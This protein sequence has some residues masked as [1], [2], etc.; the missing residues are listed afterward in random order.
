MPWRETCTMHERQLFIDAWLSRDF[1]LSYLCERFGISR[2]TGYKWIGRFRAEGDL[3][4]TDRSRAR[5]SQAHR[6]PDAVIEQI[7]N[8]KHQHPSWGPVTLAGKLYREN[9]N[10]HWPAVSTIGEILKRHGLVKPRRKRHKTPPH[11]AP[12]AHARAPNQVWSADFKGQFRLG[13]GRWCYPLTISDNHSRMLL[14]C[15]GL[16]GPRYRL[17]R[18]ACEQVFREYG[19]PE[20]IRTDNGV[21]FAARALGGLCP[22][23]IW[24]IRLEVMPERIEPGC[25]QQN[26]RHERMHRTLKAE[27]VTPPRYNFSAQQRAFNR[28]RLEYNEQRPHQSLGRGVCPIDCHEPATRA[29]PETLPEIEYPDPWII[30]KVKQQGH[31]KLHG[32]E[33]YLTKS[34]AGE[35][36]G[37]ELI[38]DHRW[39]IYFGILKLGILDG[40][41]QRVIRPK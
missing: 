1:E 41:L 26:P 11:T 39:L 23:S 17:T 35:H 22:L 29:Y 18:K 37:L 3:G 5:K 14:C 13:D 27:A 10:R 40:R 31:I 36:V 21:P 25:P 34:L 8:L 20:R 16:P 24:L 38:D 15:Q 19:L 32:H 9:P 30:R 33:I 2:K 4:L 28:F 7:L 6:T 12:L